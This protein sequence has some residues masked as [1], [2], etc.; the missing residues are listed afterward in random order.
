MTELYFRISHFGELSKLGINDPPRVDQL[1]ALLQKKIQTLY[2]GVIGFALLILATFVFMMTYFGIQFSKVSD[3]GKGCEQNLKFVT[4]SIKEEIALAGTVSLAFLLIQIPAMVVAY[5]YLRTAVNTHFPVSLTKEKW[6][7]KF[8]FIVFIVTYLISLTYAIV[9]PVVRVIDEIEVKLGPQML[10]LYCLYIVWDIPRILAI[11]A[12]HHMNFG[13][14]EARTT[15]VDEQSQ[16][17]ESEYLISDE[18][19]PYSPTE[20]SRDSSINN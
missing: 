3:E 13:Y 8:L 12:M 17:S 20:S 14:K 11:L 19:E 5:C 6:N 16:V 9:A 4:D 7:I 1:E 10:I 2:R 15:S 18:D